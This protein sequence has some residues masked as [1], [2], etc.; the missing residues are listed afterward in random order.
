MMAKKR[1][2]NRFFVCIDNTGYPTSLE[3][4]KI[5]ASIPDKAAAARGYLRVIDESGEDYL[6]PASRFVAIAVP[7]AARAAFAGVA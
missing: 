3:A 6:Y 2:T 1:M 4:R 5:Y 7:S